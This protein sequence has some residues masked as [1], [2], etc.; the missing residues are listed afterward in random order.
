MLKRDWNRIRAAG[1]KH[2]RTVRGYRTRERLRNEDIQNE[3]GIFPVYEVI[4]VCRDK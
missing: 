3:F 4:T 1:M 2:V